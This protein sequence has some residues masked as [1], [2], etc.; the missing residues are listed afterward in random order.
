MGKT[1]PPVPRA[2]VQFQ[3]APSADPIPT[4]AAERT[5]ATRSRSRSLAGVGSRL[6]PGQRGAFCPRPLSDRASPP[7]ASTIGDDSIPR[8]PRRRA[9]SARAASE[10][11]RSSAENLCWSWEPAPSDFATCLTDFGKVKKVRRTEANGGELKIAVGSERKRTGANGSEL[12]GERKRTEANKK[13]SRPF[14][15]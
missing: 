8:H 15:R 3:T 13:I 7:R 10:S 14:E 2:K 11:I 5:G 6:S 1:A 4:F 9:A 12:C